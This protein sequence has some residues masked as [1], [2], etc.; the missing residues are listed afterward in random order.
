MSCTCKANLCKVQTISYL[1]A[2]DGGLGGLLGAAGGSAVHNRLTSTDGLE[3]G[4]RSGRNRYACLVRYMAG[5]A[6]R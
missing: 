2:P 4:F 5:A 1:P 3:I 6:L